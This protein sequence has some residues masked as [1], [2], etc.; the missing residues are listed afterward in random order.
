[1]GG[2]GRAA[3]VLERLR[4]IVPVMLLLT[5]IGG[6]SVRGFQ[7]LFPTQQNFLQESPQPWTR[8]ALCECLQQSPGGRVQSRESSAI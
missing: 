2:K 5:G 6:N 7:S 1:M 8:L 3:R 4:D